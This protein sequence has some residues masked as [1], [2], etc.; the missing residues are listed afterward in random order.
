[1]GNVLSF[2]NFRETQLSLGLGSRPV[3]EKRHVHIQDQAN[4]EQFEY[5][6]NHVRV[7]VTL[8][9]SVTLKESCKGQG[10]IQAQHAY[11]HTKLRPQ[12]QHQ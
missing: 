12:H 8:K 4:N 7:S 2:K 6:S 11:S 9:D 10:K 3:E 5:R 1:M